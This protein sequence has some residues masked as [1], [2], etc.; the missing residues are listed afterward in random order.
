[1]SDYAPT[2]IETFPGKVSE[3]L[4]E[5]FLKIANPESVASAECLFKLFRLNAPLNTLTLISV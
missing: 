5:E 1:M 4:R 2:L 3:I